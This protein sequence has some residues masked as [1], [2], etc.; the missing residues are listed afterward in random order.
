MGMRFTVARLVPGAR[1]AEP[2]ALCRHS[3]KTCYLIQITSGIYF[4][5]VVLDDVKMFTAVASPKF[6]F[7]LIKRSG[8]TFT[9]RR[10]D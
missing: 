3:G 2:M 6:D 4:A 1:V 8:K 10:V 9:Y 5:Q 7:L